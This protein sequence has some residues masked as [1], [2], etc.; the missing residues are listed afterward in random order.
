VAAKKNATPVA[1]PVVKKAIE[2][3]PKVAI[4]AVKP[5]VLVV[6]PKTPQFTKNT[7]AES[8]SLQLDSSQDLESVV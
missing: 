4:Q 2:I 5:K 7:S 1:S 6:K 8:Q 3:K